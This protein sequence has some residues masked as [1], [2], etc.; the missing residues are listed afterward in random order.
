[1]EEKKEK[2]FV[3]GVRFEKPREGAPEFV[4]GRLSFKVDEA[5]A[6]L[7]KHKTESGWVNA[8][9]KKS[10]GGKLYLELNTFVPRK[11]EELNVS[12]SENYPKSEGEVAF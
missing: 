9:L 6:F 2:I 8:D 5:V 12:S 10:A 7:Q 1:M 11:R 4:K 3:D